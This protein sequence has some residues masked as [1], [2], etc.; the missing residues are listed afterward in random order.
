MPD[1]Y[2]PE[3]R[4]TQY[5]RQNQG[6][7]YRKEHGGDDGHGELTV[8][9]SRGTGEKDH[10]SE[11]GRQH[12]ADANQRTC[13]LLHG[14]GR[15]FPGREPF[16][17]HDPCHVFH[18]HNRVVHQQADGQDHRKHGQ[19]VDGKTEEIQNG[20][21]SQ[22]N[23]RHR[24]RGNQRGSKVAEEKPHHQEHE[25]DR[26]NKRLDNL[27]DGHLDEGCGVH[28][29]GH[30][31]PRGEVTAQFRHLGLDGI[32]RIQRVGAGG[33]SNGD[34]SR[35]FSIEHGLDVID[36]CP[37]LGAAHIT[38]PHDGSVR[39]GAQGNVCK[40][41]G[42][43]KHVLNDDGCVQTLPLHRR[44]SSELA[45]GYLHIVGLDRR[46]H[47]RHGQT[48]I[49]QL[50]RIEPNAHGIPAAIDLHLADTRHTR[51]NRFQRRFGIVRQI[52]VV[53]SA[54]FRDQSHH[55][56]VIPRGFD[57][58]DTPIF[59]HVGQACLGGLGLVLNLRPGKIGTGSRGKRQ[60]Q[61]GAA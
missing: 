10:R 7:D 47:I 19:H 44:R 14:F 25:E 17:G 51:Q 41:L 53:H 56:Q 57:D 54:V 40:L 58:L 13:D 30:F 20:K 42:G 59:D 9:D 61:T 39:I 55:H 34:A 37:Q 46:D 5:R 24:D 22:K 28:G 23:H 32:G 36:L 38:D 15:G 48:V 43:R 31:D 1:L 6:H 3:Q 11:Y 27:P 18:H 45:G 35:L 2:I 50:F 49:R 60:L 33:L 12:Q 21:G 26:D 52:D 8:D 16:F 4:G 29:I